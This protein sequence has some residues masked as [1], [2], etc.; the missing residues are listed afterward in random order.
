MLPGA[1][2]FPSLQRASPGHAGPRQWEC[3]LITGRSLK[4]SVLMFL[5]KRLHA[6]VCGN[7]LF[8]RARR[9][10][11]ETPR[12]ATL[13]FALTQHFLIQNAFE[14]ICLMVSPRWNL[15]PQAKTQGPFCHCSQ[16][17]SSPS[18]LPPRDFVL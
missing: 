16:G 4:Y 18:P 5:G 6:Y 9:H 12:N 7:S 10:P 1:L 8:R 14:Y 13:C 17:H 2:A 3:F 11:K 15:V